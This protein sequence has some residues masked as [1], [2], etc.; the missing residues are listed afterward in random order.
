[1]AKTKE[2]RLASDVKTGRKL[3]SVS[4]TVGTAGKAFVQIGAVLLLTGFAIALLA[5]LKQYQAGKLRKDIFNEKR[6]KKAA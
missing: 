1:M 5:A 4:D 6:L 2:E 3:F